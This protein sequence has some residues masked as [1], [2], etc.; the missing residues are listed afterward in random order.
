MDPITLVI[1]ALGAGA[2]AALN[3]TAGQAVRDAYA[4]LKK[5]LKRKL[6]DAAGADAILDRHEAKPEAWDGAVTTILK[7]TNAAEDEEVIAAAKKL[8][9]LVDP[10]GAAT[11]K[12][13]VV[14]SGGQVGVIGDHGTAYMG[15]KPEPRRDS[16]TE[17][18]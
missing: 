11:G 9:E 5:L 10:A 2:V 14:V 8:L 1:S 6:G 13:N 12:Y 3:E 4:G 15:T 7:E 16:T 17:S 18:R